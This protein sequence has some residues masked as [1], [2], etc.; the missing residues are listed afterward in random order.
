MRSILVH[1]VA[2]QH[3]IALRF[4]QWAV[5]RAANFHTLV[6]R[7]SGTQL[8]M[9]LYMRELASASYTGVNHFDLERLR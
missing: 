5:L 8:A 4:A 3:C 7:T 2:K 1:S 9:Y 6:C